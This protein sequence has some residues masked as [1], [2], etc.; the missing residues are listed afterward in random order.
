[1][2]TRRNQNVDVYSD[3]IK[4]IASGEDMWEDACNDTL[5]EFRNNYIF[6]FSALPTKTQFTELGVKES[7]FVS[8]GRRGETNRSVLD[9]AIGRYLP[10]ALKLGGR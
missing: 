2:A 8:L 4:M 7:G 6:K 5:K 1:M 9:I 10:D 3:A